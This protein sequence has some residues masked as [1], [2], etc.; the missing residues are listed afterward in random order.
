MSH[1]IATGDGRARDLSCDCC[2]TFWRYRRFSEDA[3]DSRLTVIS[4]E[5][6]CG[7]RIECC[8]AFGAYLKTY[9]GGNEVLLTDG[10]SLHLDV[11]ASDRGLKRRAVSLYEI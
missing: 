9:S 11:V 3:D 5:G 7:L 2:H 6:E 8:Q 10:T 1:L 4:F